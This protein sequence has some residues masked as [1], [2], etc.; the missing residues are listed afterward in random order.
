MH[1]GVLYVDPAS[2]DRLR[3]EM[4]VRQRLLIVNEP[5]GAKAQ[6]MRHSLGDLADAMR[7][8]A[9]SA[10]GAGVALSKFGAFS[11]SAEPMQALRDYDLEAGAERLYEVLAPLKAAS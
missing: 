4:E 2:Y 10:E 6:R 8:L 7:D 3:R 9:R 5:P 1:D 11:M